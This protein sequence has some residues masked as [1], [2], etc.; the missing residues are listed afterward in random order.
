MDLLTIATIRVSSVLNRD[1]KSYG[2]KYLNDGNMET[3]WN[4][5]QGTGQWILLE[6]SAPVKPTQ[7]SI[8]FQGGFAGKNCELIADQSK[9]CDF[10]PDDVNTLQQFPI[11]LETEIT[12]LKILFHDSTDFY[13]RV[14][15]YHLGLQ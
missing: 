14:T 1:A 10:Y 7:L 2:K 3:C 15:I 6:F 9:L 13:G 11:Q 4:S 5:D 12:K 8:M